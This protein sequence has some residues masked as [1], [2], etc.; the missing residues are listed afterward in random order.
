MVVILQAY[1]ICHPK[2]YDLIAKSGQRKLYTS[3]P[4][5]D[6]SQFNHVIV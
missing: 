6:K 2:R 3:T 1:P 4:P 5:V